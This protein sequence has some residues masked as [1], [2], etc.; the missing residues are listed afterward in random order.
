MIDA[1][2]VDAEP[3]MFLSSMFSAPARNFFNSETV[4]F[5]IVR[6]GREI[7]PVI[8]SLDIA[9]HLNSVDQYTN[10]EFT[11]P[12]HKEIGTFNGFDMINR[13]AGQDPFTD[14]DFMANAMGKSVELIR[15]NSNKITRT[16]E[17]QASQVLQ[18]GICTLKDE[19][20][21][22]AFT[23]DYKPKSAHFPTA[24]TAWTNVSTAP[25]DRDW[26]TCEA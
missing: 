1:V 26:E 17:L 5:D 11:P 20:N 25:F 12:I 16:N 21:V 15:K 4:E 24:G 8:T 19:N 2:R 14:P 18:T 23:I 10:K 3:T 7:A 22:D 9:G 6:G 13:Q